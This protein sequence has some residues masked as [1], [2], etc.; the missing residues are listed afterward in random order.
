MKLMKTYRLIAFK[1]LCVKLLKA[2]FGMS[3][4][5]KNRVFILQI[6]RAYFIFQQTDIGLLLCPREQL[7]GTCYWLYPKAFSFDCPYCENACGWPE[8]S[9]FMN[10]LWSNSLHSF[11]FKLKRSTFPPFNS[12]SHSSRRDPKVHIGDIIIVLVVHRQ[13]GENPNSWGY[14]FV[15]MITCYQ[16]FVRHFTACYK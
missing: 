14:L 9:C 4:V 2:L 11:D 8:W 3:T 13:T 1:T 12:D 16:V 5:C 10:F 7:Q 6:L 15:M